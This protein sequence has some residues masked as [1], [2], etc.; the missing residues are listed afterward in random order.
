LREGEENVQGEPPHRRRRIEGLGD[1]NEGH[2][3]SVEDFNKLREIHQGPAEP[4]NLVDDH[5][6]N[7]S[8]FYVG[9]KFFQRR[10]VESATG[11]TAVVI[12]LR[13]FD[14]PFRTLARNIGAAG[15]ALS[16]Q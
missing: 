16:V 14:P 1:A 9:K 7:A 11:Y 13:Q 10:P 15:L 3:T 2:V 4:V 6:I 12:L 8:D 5:D